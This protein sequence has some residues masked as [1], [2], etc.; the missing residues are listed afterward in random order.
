MTLITVFIRLTAIGDE[1]IQT[2]V[3]EVRGHMSAL[4]KICEAIGMLDMVGP[5]RVALKSSC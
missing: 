4:F 2:L 3:E 1:A 5:P